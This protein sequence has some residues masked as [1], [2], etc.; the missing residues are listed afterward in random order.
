MTTIEGTFEGGGDVVVKDYPERSRYEATV[1]GEPAGYAEYG[2]TDDTITFT[3]TVV[4]PAFRG[5]GIAGAL[6]GQALD[7]VRRVGGRQVI[8]ACPYVADFM[9]KNPQYADLLG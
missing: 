2:L 8:P 5:R 9:A 7:E 3:H 1:D 4:D 6:V